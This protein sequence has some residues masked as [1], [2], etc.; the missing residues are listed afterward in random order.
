[1]DSILANIFL[2]IQERL[3]EKVPE[4]SFIDL[5]KGQLDSPEIDPAVTFP[6]ALINLDETDYSDEGENSQVGESAVLIRLG[7]SSSQV[8]NVTDYYN[9]E[10]KVN[11]SLH[12]WSDSQ[13]FTPL[14][15]RKVSKEKRNDDI[16]VR[17]I[18][19]E[20]S[21]RDSTGIEGGTSV[22]RP[23]LELELD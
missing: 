1:M 10:H 11:K 3:T 16:W 19:Y 5:D 23:G 22:S 13:C 8:E 20:F 6:C 14:M 17:V 7:I 21:F 18:R 9:L 2:K 12:G 4:L 15:R